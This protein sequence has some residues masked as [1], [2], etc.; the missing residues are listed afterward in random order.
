MK[1]KIN[2]FSN[3]SSEK[4]LSQLF[5]DLLITSKNLNELYNDKIPTEGG[6]VLINDSLEF[7][8]INFKKMNKEFLFF[9]NIAPSSNIVIK[10]PDIIKSPLLISQIRSEIKKFLS[11][12]SINFKDIEVIDRELINVKNNNSCKITDIEYEIL[13]YLITSKDCSKEYIKNNILMIKSSLMT[14]SLDS[15]LTR[16]R[17]KLDK[18]QTGIKIKASND[19]LIIYTN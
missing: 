2:F 6:V 17:K 1:K 5:P 7:T 13:T 10:N 11:N 15:H 19:K 12:K 16:I 4:F 3:Q 18:L 8:K 9:S 14:N